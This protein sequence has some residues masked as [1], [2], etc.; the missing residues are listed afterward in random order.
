MSRHLI[1]VYGSLLSGLGNHRVI[2]DKE[3][4]LKGTMETKPEYSLYDLGY[5][6]GLK[7]EGTTSIKL[8]IYE[9]NDRISKNVEALEGY[10][11]DEPATFYDKKTIDTPWGEASIYIYVPNVREDRLVESGDWKE[12]YLNKVKS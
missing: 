11:P 1:A 10:Y 7:E 6:P 3:T 2:E 4:T 12:H 5:Y 9:V 8:E